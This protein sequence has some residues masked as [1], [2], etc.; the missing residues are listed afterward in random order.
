MSAWNLGSELA[1]SLGMLDFEF[2]REY[3]AKGLTPHNHEGQPHMPA[4]VVIQFIEGLE[5]ELAHHDDMAWS[6]YGREREEFI[7]NRIIPLQERIQVYRDYLQ[8]LNGASWEGYEF[9]QD[10]DLSAHFIGVLLNSYYPREEVYKRL[11]SPAGTS[12]GEGSV[13]LPPIAEKAETAVKQR[14]LRPEQRYKLA[15]RESAEKIWEEDPN[16]TI[17][18][19]IDRKEITHACQGTA[20]IRNTIRNWIKDLC[21]NRNPGRPKKKKI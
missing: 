16:L 4:G 11:S 6:L 19:M 15:C 8:S 12:P 2:A 20:Y 5:D 7:A 9:P 21:P 1:A 10:K 17:E 18:K 14:K 13:Q 3:I